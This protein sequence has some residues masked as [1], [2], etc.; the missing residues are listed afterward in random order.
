MDIKKKKILPFVTKDLEGIM[1]SEI[2]SDRK[3]QIPCDVTYT[4]NLTTKTNKQLKNLILEK[5]WR[6][7]LWLPE[8]RE[9]GVREGEKL[10]E[11]KWPK[12]TNFQLKIK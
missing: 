10:E 5:D 12:G 6:F 1:L 3:K 8:A 2:K 11:S 7:N 9:Q 4:W